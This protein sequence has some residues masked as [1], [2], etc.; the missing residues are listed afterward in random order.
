MSNLITA[1]KAAISQAT[2][3]F[4]QQMANTPDAVLALHHSGKTLPEMR[5]RA[6]I[7]ATIEGIIEICKA[8][9]FEVT[10]TFENL[11]PELARNLSGLI[12]EDFK[13][14]TIAFL[15]ALLKPAR[16]PVREGV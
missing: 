15:E 4:H 3:E 2:D 7:N 6:A 14:A 16:A 11:P 13:D 12:E 10:N 1:V 8:S 5:A 9:T